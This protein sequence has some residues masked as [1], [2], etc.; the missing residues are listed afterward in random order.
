[1]YFFLNYSLL[2][3]DHLFL[4]HN[5]YIFLCSVW[6]DIACNAIV[7]SFVNDNKNF[8]YKFLFRTNPESF[9]NMANNMDKNKYA[10]FIQRRLQ[11]MQ[12]KNH[13]WKISYSFVKT[14]QKNVVL[15]HKS[16]ILLYVSI[17]IFSRTQSIT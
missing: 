14:A 5:V 3:F 7:I 8:I 16:N 10:Q 11:S 9:I 17:M 12:S 1:M 4:N 13:N 2:S 6:N 15:Q